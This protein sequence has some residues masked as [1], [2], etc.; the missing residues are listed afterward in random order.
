MQWLIILRPSEA[1]TK[2]PSFCTKVK[3]NATLLEPIRT[4]LDEYW[5]EIDSTKEG[6]YFWSHEWQKHGSCAKEL[7]TFDTELKYFSA[8]LDLRQKFDL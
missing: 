4:S 7:A 3:F 2:G 6:N 1:G 8:A 5:Y